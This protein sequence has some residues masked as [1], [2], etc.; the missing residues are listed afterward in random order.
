MVTDN[1]DRD[2]GSGTYLE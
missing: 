2:V 1:I